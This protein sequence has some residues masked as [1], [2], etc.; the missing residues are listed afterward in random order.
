MHMFRLIKESQWL[1]YITIK[2]IQEVSDQ[3]YQI[4]WS[5]IS[6]IKKMFPMNPE[7]KETKKSRQ[8]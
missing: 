2:K 1:V 6:N 7:Q 8:S 3:E 4:E 5:I